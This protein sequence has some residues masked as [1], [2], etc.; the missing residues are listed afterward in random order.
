MSRLEHA[1]DT[2]Q[3]VEKAGFRSAEVYLKSGRS[4]RFE[5]G[6]L[7]LVAGLSRETG[8]AIR[9]G[10][11]EG[12]FFSAGVGLPRLHAQHEEP[13]G[14]PLQLPPAAPLAPWNEPAGVDAPLASESEGLGLLEEI[15]ARL[16]HELPGSRLL[17]GVLDDGLSCVDIANS[18][19]VR[20]SYRARS[21][22]LSLEAIGPW[23]GTSS[24]RVYL[25]ERT[26][27]GF[28]AGPVAQRLANRLLLGHKGRPPES[29]AGELLLSPAVAVQILAA[30]YPLFVGSEHADT[31]RD[32][33]DGA[34]RLGSDE[35][36]L[37][38]DGRYPGGVLEA[39]ADGEGYPTGREVLV[40]RGIHRAILVSGS[41]G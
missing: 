30:L 28:L 41:E 2:L 6:P 37:V 8:W 23:S 19:G 11:Q 34:G 16:Q 12:S 10:R 31:L 39:P 7:G 40:E 1:G 17:W 33:C 3:V 26:A 14:P 21:S 18:R 29:S 25:A 32:L 22:S 27:R 15:Q 36:T 9:G 20:C 38:D 13:A 24:T 35:L 5:L 4:R